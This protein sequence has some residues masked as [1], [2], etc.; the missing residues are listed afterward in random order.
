MM[1]WIIL[2]LKDGLKIILAGNKLWDDRFCNLVRIEWII[3]R[4][5]IDHEIH[6]RGQVAA[7]LPVLKDKQIE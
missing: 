4:G 3:F 1:C 6:H 7:Y 2:I 5:N